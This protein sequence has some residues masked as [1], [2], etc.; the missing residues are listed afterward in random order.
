MRRLFFLSGLAFLAAVGGIFLSS[1]PTMP[2]AKEPVAARIPASSPPS[3]QPAPSASSAAPVAKKAPD[4]MQALSESKNCL[5]S[6]ACDFPQTDPRSYSFAVGRQIAE[7]L[8]ALGAAYSEN[9]SLESEVAEAAREFMLVQ[10]GFVQEQAMRLMGQLPISSA[11]VDAMLSGLEN[12]PDP[13]L[14]EQAMKEWERYIGTAEE[15]RI[16]EFLAGFI[17]HGGQFSSEKASEMILGFLNERSVPTFEEK[18]ASMVPESTPARYLRA[19]LD[20]YHRQ[21]Q[22][23]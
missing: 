12:S 17:A 18:L 3:P 16:Q 14:V 2:P 6:E 13:L 5:E 1:S 22:G 15:A 19:A 7:Q 4:L 8:S 10:D 23:G 11:N 9:P 20:Q 21:R